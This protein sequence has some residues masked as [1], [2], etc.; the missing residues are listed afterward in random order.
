M[1]HAAYVWPQPRGSRRGLPAS[2]HCQGQAGFT[3]G[4]VWLSLTSSLVLPVVL[5]RVVVFGVESVAVRRLE[6][7]ADGAAV[8]SRWWKLG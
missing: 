4:P 8:P 2:T 7:H 3:E 5:V 1:G 6:P